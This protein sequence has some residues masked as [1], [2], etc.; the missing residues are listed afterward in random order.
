MG[1]KKDVNDIRESAALKIIPILNTL[2][3]KVYYNDPY[4]G[5]ISDFPGYPDLKMTSVLLDYNSLD[6]YDAVMVLTDHSC[7]DWEKIIKNS[8]LVIDTRNV[9]ANIV[10]TKKVIKA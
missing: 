4:V 3:A 7:Y 2:L 8:D 6:L 9:S 1:Y 5:A 10:D